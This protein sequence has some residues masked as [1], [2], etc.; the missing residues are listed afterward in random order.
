MP[1]LLVADKPAREA[2]TDRQAGRQVGLMLG[3]ELDQ[4]NDM[5]NLF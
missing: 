5:Q 3:A 1:G 4:L 2:E